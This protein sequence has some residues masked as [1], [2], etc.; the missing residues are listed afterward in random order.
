[1]RRLPLLLIAVFL[2]ALAGSMIFFWIAY[3]TAPDSFL[4]LVF[5]GVVILGFF[6]WIW[7][8]IHMLT[9]QTLQGTEKIVWAI[10]I[11]FL[12]VLGAILYFLVSPFVRLNPPKQ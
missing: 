1:M 10:V 3:A 9:N 8:L 7:A 6:I 2:L 11:V 12:N 5:L 4:P